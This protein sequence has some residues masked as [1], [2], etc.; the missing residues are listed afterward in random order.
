MSRS[1]IV[2][3]ARTPMGRL[4][5]SLKDFSASD[6]GGIAIKAALERAG[7][8]SERVDYVIMGQ[9]LT[10]GAGQIPA[11]H[12][13]VKAGAPTSVPA[14][15]VNKVCL[16]CLN[17]TALAGPGEGTSYG[18][19]PLRVQLAYDGLWCAFTDQGMGGHTVAGNGGD[20]YFSGQ[21][22]NAFAAR[23][24]QLAARAWKNGVMEDEVVAVPSPQR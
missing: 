11:R 22:R 20:R 2:S 21:E 8:A 23:S 7:V 24:H 15:T 18:E 17:A 16:S 13:A 10:A 12:V 4:L 6:L 19:D 9:V 1:V 5:G 14:P 3:G